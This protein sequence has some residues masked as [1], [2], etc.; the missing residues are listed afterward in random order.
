VLVIRVYDNVSLICKTFL[1]SGLQI[2]IYRAFRKEGTGGRG[3]EQEV[4][5]VP[6]PSVKTKNM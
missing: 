2:F 6:E 5:G 1:G 3:P 4:Y